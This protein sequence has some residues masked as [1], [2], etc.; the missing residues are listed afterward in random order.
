MVYIK[1][2]IPSEGD[3]F[4]G[5]NDVV[6]YRIGAVHPKTP[7]GEPLMWDNK[8]QLQSV[9]TI[10]L[11]LC[12]QGG[13]GVRTDAEVP[14]DGF[15][16]FAC[17]DA[18]K[19]QCLTVFAGKELRSLTGVPTTHV[20]KVRDDLYI[21][22]S[23]PL[24]SGELKK[25]AQAGC[26]GSA[27][28]TVKDP[29]HANCV[30]RTSLMGTIPVAVIKALRLIEKGQQLLLKMGSVMPFEYAKD[31]FMLQRIDLSKLCYTPTTHPALSVMFEKVD[32][33]PAGIASGDVESNNEEVVAGGDVES[34]VEIVEVAVVK[35]APKKRKLETDDEE[36]APKAPK[37][38]ESDA[39]SILAK[40]KELRKRAR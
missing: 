9:T 18:V 16:V 28:N 26:I 4:P 36:E 34:D 39:R 19:D 40:N 24:G 23:V 3:D 6:G 35:A 5:Q 37:L 13:V 17:E 10:P 33:P 1:Y 2:D 38:T 21:D 7:S 25:W 29:R 11:L 27:V 31:D 32:P 15:S 22:G 8:G 30:I 12:R 20:L 14:A